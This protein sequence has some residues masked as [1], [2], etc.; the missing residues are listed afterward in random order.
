MRTVPHVRRSDVRGGRKLDGRHRGL[1]A[2]KPRK[3]RLRAREREEWQGQ[4]S[5]Y[6]GQGRGGQDVVFRVKNNSLGGS[7][8]KQLRLWLSHSRAPTHPPAPLPAP[9]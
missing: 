5:T 3:W 8:F 6:V 7:L 4:T 1:L 2:A 9:S